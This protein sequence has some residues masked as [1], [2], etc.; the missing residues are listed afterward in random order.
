LDFAGFPVFPQ[1]PGNVKEYG[2][3]EETEADPLVVF[4][5]S[6]FFR[7]DGLVDTGMRHINADSLPES[8]G[9][10][11]GGVNPAVS[12]EHIFGNVLGV[13]TVNGVAHVLPGG[14]D[15]RKGQQAHHREGVMQPEDGAVNMHMADL[16]QVFEA[17]EY[18][19]HFEVAKL[20]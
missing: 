18:V 2:L 13:N 19:Y 20:S 5:V 11:V 10:G 4:D 3:K 12:V 9:D 16:D 15:E 17:A 7:V 1:P 14:D 8:T 6:S